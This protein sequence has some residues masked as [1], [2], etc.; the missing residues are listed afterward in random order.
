MDELLEATAVSGA[1]RERTSEHPHA[2]THS[3]VDMGVNTAAAA[4]QGK[5]VGRK[6]E[7]TT[8]PDSSSSLVAEAAFGVDMAASERVADREVVAGVVANNVDSNGEPQR[9]ESVSE[10]VVTATSTAVAGAMTTTTTTTTT[11]TKTSVTVQETHT[12]IGSEGAVVKFIRQGGSVTAAAAKFGLSR[13][14]VSKIVKDAA[15]AS[16]EGL[17]DSDTGSDAEM[18]EDDSSVDA[19]AAGEGSD[20]QQATRKRKSAGA[21]GATTTAVAAATENVS[22]DANALTP[23]KVK[24]ATTTD[25]VS[26]DSSAKAKR[27]RKSKEE[28]LAILDF[29]E[30]GGTHVAAAEKFG[31]SRTAVTKMVKDKE[32]IW[33]KVAGKVDTTA[34]AQAPAEGS[35]APMD[36]DALATNNAVDDLAI[37]IGAPATK[38]ERAAAAP[39]S[40]LTSGTLANRKGRRVRKTNVEKLEILA[41]VEQGGSQGAAAE[42][43]GVSR[44]AVTKMVKEKD[45]ISAQAT[46]DSTNHRK[47]LQYQHKLSIIEDMLYKWQV[48][49]EFEAPNLKVTGDLLQN[50]AMEF[51]NKI[52]ADF[53]S[54]LPDEVVVSLTDF[55]AS[56]GWLHRYTQR[57]NV[58]SMSKNE[59][60]SV[61]A[62]P[63]YV[64]KRME[65]IRSQ[66][67]L[68]HV[69]L[70]CIWN[71]DEAVIRHRTTSS[72]VDAPINLDSRSQ[73]KM[74]V[75]FGVSA[76]GEK[77]NLQ[78]IGASSQPASLKEV[79]PVLTF[80]VYYHGQRKACQDSSTLMHFVN[81]MNHEARSR[82]QIWYIL[83]DNCPSH[84]AAASILDPSGSY[85][86]GFRVDSV[87]LIV[88]PP[89][90]VS[91]LQPLQL[92]VIRSFKVAF[93]REMLRTI[94]EEYLDWDAHQTTGGGGAA[95]QIGDSNSN[96]Q[97][98]S[99]DVHSF[100][101]SQN[102]LLWL[103][104]AW[105]STSVTSIRQAWAKSNYLPTHLL[106]ELSEDL[107]RPLDSTVY[108]DFLQFL[109]V[110]S[111]KK[112]LLAT[113]GLD[114]ID[115]PER[116][117]LELVNLDDP[118]SSGSNNDVND[119]EIVMESLSA[120]GLI[121]ESQ[122]IPTVASVG[123]VAGA[124]IPDSTPEIASFGEACSAVEK[125]L[126]FMDKTTHEQVP[127]TDRRAGRS[128]L[129]ALHRVLLKARAKERSNTAYTV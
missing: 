52:L 87:V 108:D 109:P 51:R 6:Q 23:A 73:E 17:G 37:T 74:T 124:V 118:D 84:M 67:S 47:V 44:T 127:A 101:H 54:D 42:K 96:G 9:D 121:R 66:L 62:D 128:N 41:F 5:R 29:V 77:L 99:F 92:G 34:S 97:L 129:L 33:S 102:A 18:T 89:N 85:D 81:L 69:P 20:Q 103:Q 115:D 70:Q 95:E 94:L 125:L 82:K 65:R 48:Q 110:L 39:S 19:R 106:P 16:A 4:P 122:R 80:G 58:R 98:A 126:R 36:I 64:E 100:T 43:F 27:V 49:V 22:G 21:D 35:S 93:R 30:Q 71:I 7:L 68:A 38:K 2:D 45:A 56:N 107:S 83:L 26:L 3:I 31:I 10:V 57:R 55:K 61:S 60:H 63:A 119:D 12:E 25:D 120:Q 46:S 14:D 116:L 13:M 8:D 90:S 79:D 114:S 76:A 59:H 113:L 53:S 123:A 105:N 11:T 91:S 72:R 24:T 86:S 28:K 32:L 15:E 117:V 88:L 78:A 104:R 112:Q 40:P 75:A 1:P 50:K 111:A